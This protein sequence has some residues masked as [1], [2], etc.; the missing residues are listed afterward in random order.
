MNNLKHEFNITRKNLKY[1]GREPHSLKI[2]LKYMGISKKEFYETIK[3][4]VVYPNQMTIKKEKS[5][6]MSDFKDWYNEN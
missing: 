4:Q 1:D 3:E 2:F 5:Q 6:K